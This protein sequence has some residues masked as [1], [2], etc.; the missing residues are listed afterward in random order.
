MQNER[1][2]HP[3]NLWTKRIISTFNIPSSMSCLA[4]F[5]ISTHHKHFIVLFINFSQISQKYCFAH[6]SQRIISYTIIRLSFATCQYIFASCCEQ[7]TLLLFG[8]DLFITV[9]KEVFF[10]YCWWTYLLPV[11]ICL[12][13]TS[14][15]DTRLCYAIGRLLDQMICER[16]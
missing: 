2:T 16:L 5:T 1:L 3:F 9:C 4:K 10:S 8:H 13:K 6:E 11:C 15:D 12:V 14:F 7:S